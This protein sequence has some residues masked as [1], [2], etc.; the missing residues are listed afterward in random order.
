MKY[1]LGFYIFGRLIPYYGLLIALG[2]VTACVIATLLVKKAGLDVYDMIILGTSAGLGGMIGS[3]LLY[4]IQ[5]LNNIDFSRLKDLN[6]FNEVMAGGFVFFGG[7]IGFLIVV[8]GFYIFSGYDIPRYLNLLI[9]V[10]P[11]A[12]GFGRIGCNLVGCCFGKEFHGACARVYTASMFAP[13]NIP[14]FPVQLVEAC[15]EFLIGGYLIF[16]VVKSGYK[17]K[18]TAVQYLML[19][20][21]VRFVLEYYRGDIE[22]KIYGWFSTSQWISIGIVVG[23]GIYLVVKV[24]NNK[25]DI[26]VGD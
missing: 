1:D 10:V 13:N 21:L 3:K 20:S 14:L 16:V 23:C 5:N 25:K 26:N 6:Y 7:I 24:L 9:P 11:I 4:I 8:L 2:V 22:R 19:Y 12:H 17:A 15:F 18:T